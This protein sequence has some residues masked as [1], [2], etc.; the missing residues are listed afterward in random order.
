MNDL[1][2]KMRQN[3]IPIYFVDCC[4]FV[5]LGMEKY[6]GG[7]H[8]ICA[9][10]T[11]NG[12]H[13]NIFVPKSFTYNYS[14]TSEDTVNALLRNEE[15]IDYIQKNGKGKL[16][17]WMLDET[18]ESLAK[19]LG[20]EI[21]LPPV[22]VRNRWDHKA[23]TNRLAELAGVPCVP[24]VLS[25]VEDYAHL[26]R[27]AAHLGPDW[28]VQMPYGFGGETTFFISDES[29]FEK[30]QH[31]ITNGEEM[32][33]M[34]RIDCISTG[35]EGCVTRYGIVTS[36][37]L[38]ELTGIRELN[39]YLGGWSGNELFFNAFPESTLLS[40]QNYTIKM[41]EQLRRVGYNGYFELDFLIDKAT[42][43]LY[44]G[45]MNL[46]FCGF[47]QM[48]ANTPM[49]QQDAPLFLLHLAEWLDISYNLDIESLNRRWMIPSPNH[50]LS[51][52]Y[53]HNVLE[54]LMKPIPSGIY[55]MNPDETVVFARPTAYPPPLNADE[56]FWFSVIP[57]TQLLK[58]GYELGGFLM[59]AR[60]TM[61]G[62]QLTS[63]T[64]AW[65]KGLTKI[66]N[67]DG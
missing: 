49:I 39:L 27:L 40:A 66:G 65:I 29:D 16:L 28:V 42:Q 30:Y 55:R 25:S 5:A 20:L 19:E 45:E 41:G 61:D 21:C 52:L 23:N 10:D 22:A 58:K 56:I 9:A 31:F 7:L 12:L 14:S 64:K 17:T 37:L 53:M 15:V 50:S 63:K 18:T 38:L 51:F 3:T 11:F 36:P 34:K 67:L 43:M 62:K 35:L 4:L 8:F 24:Y 33:I 26:R 2:N 1:K 32:K 57:N 46:R 48:L 54:S 59:F 13:P 47:T 60:A 44:L 6:V